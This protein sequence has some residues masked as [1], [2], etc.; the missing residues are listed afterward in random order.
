MNKAVLFS[1]CIAAV[2]LAG[3]KPELAEVAYGAE[4]E[5]WEK[6]ISSSYSGYRPPQ[7]PPPAVVDKAMPEALE[8]QRERQEQ[9]ADNSVKDKEDSPVVEA[10]PA[11]AVDEAAA[12]TEPAAPA[13]E[14]KKAAPADKK[15]PAV[16]AEKKAEAKEKKAADNGDY[17]LYVVKAG[18][19]P[20][21]IAQK[22][23][24]KASF[25][26]IILKAN[27]QIKD[28]RQIRIGTKVKVPKL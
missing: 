26:E 21:S 11:K 23:Y 1:G 7:T 13:K 17:T 19:T 18:D 22:F 3:C 14:E 6:A 25:Y 20:G 16:K 15:E 28:P 8:K 10:D 5:Q 24:G 2:L 12:K 4:E 9:A 27:P